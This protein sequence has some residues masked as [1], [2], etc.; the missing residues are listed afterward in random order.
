M[1]VQSWP[2]CIAHYSCPKDE[3]WLFSL[4]MALIIEE[5]WLLRN[6]AFYQG[7]HIDIQVA[8]S[9]IHFKMSKLSACGIRMN[10]PYLSM[11]LSNI[12]GSPIPWAG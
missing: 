11:N 2:T 6:Q 1:K 5:I 12:H 3:Q 4:N 7:I 10:P 9:H 8:I